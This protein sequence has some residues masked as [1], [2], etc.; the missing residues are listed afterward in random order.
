MF[1]KNNRLDDLIGIRSISGNSAGFARISDQYGI[2][3]NSMKSSIATKNLMDSIT[4]ANILARQMTSFNLGVSRDF[5][6]A[7]KFQRNLIKNQV[8]F[9]SIT[10]VLK[11]NTEFNKAFNHNFNSLIKSQ[12]L[13]KGLKPS[14][15]K[16]TFLPSEKLLDSMAMLKATL[17]INRPSRAIIDS[18]LGITNAYQKFAVKQ[19][20]LAS[21]EK[22]EAKANKLLKVT[23]VAGNI[24][25]RN[26]I[27]NKKRSEMIENV[28][29]PERDEYNTQ[30]YIDKLNIFSLL[31][32]HVS[33]VYREDFNEDITKAV[34]NSLPM[35]ANKLGSEIVYLVYEINNS[36]MNTYG[37][38]IFKPTNKS[39][40]G[41]TLISSYLTTNENEFAEIVDYLFFMLYEGSGAAKRLIN[42]VQDEL[43]DPL[44]EVKH[45]RLN[46]R[47]DV[48]HGENISK[49]LM[50]VG[51]V[52]CNL[53]G[54]P[55]PK[56]VNDWKQAQVRLYFQIVDM[57]NSIYKLITAKNAHSVETS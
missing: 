35:I 32:Q 19:L 15:L 29:E 31:N 39:F 24:V 46:Y 56:S 6:D 10:N 16:D 41:S 49:K 23:E 27:I 18:T 54:K 14:Y 37:E 45:L 12:N 1:K 55:K 53:I 9:K 21:I 33:H 5:V 2:G 57:L 47:H 20:R 34:D 4:S 42:L 28:I 30:H 38:H 44:W 50:Q 8:D 52:Y 13:L 17:E 48:E 11:I 7:Y 3:F 25:L 22:V 36:W 43:L 26:N 51:E 40:Y